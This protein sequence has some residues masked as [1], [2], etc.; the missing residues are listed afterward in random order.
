MNTNSKQVFYTIAFLLSALLTQQRAVCQRTVPGAYPTGTPVNYVRTWDAVAP[1]ADGSAVSGRAVKDMR[2]GTQYID[3]LGRPLQTVVKQ[4]SMA[5]GASAR[6]MVSTVEYDDQGRVRYQYLPYAESSATNGAFKNDPFA[7][8]ASFMNTTYYSSQGETWYYGQTNFEASPLDRPAKSMPP[9]NNWVGSSRGVVSKYWNNTADDHVKKWWVT[10][11]STANQLPTC[12]TGNTTSYEYP[13]GELTKS[14]SVDEHGKQVV[15][16]TNKK[17]QLL[18]KKIQLTATADDGGGADHSGWLCTYYI[19]DMYDNLRCVVQPRGVELLAANSWNIGALSG[20][21]TA[22]QCFQYGYDANNRMTIKKVPGADEVRMVYDK[23]DRLVM[24]QDGNMR[25]GN[26]WLVL[27]YD[28]RSR[29]IESGLWTSSTSF[30]DHLDAAAAT[31]SYPATSGTYTIMTVTHYDDYS[32]L[33]SGL[34]SYD[35]NWNTHFSASSHTTWPYPEMPAKSSNTKGLVTWTK[36]RVIGTSDFLHAVNYY[37]EKGRVIQVQSTNH[38]GGTDITTTQ[39]SWAGQP[40]VVVQKIQ[41]AVAS[42][43]TAIVTRLTYDDLGRPSMVEKKQ[44]Y[45]GVNS[46][47]MSAFKVI[48]EMEYDKQGQMV[49][50]KIGN[51]P[52]SG[53]LETQDYE[54]NIRGWMLGMNR[55]YTRDVNDRYFG[56]DLGYDKTANG[57]INSQTYAAA[58]YNGNISGMV[59]KSKGDGAK[60]KYDFEYDAANRLIKGDFKQYNG[61]SFVNDAMINY[62]MSV[63]EFDGSGN[64]L[65]DGYDA[66][67]NIKKMLQW[68]LKVNS[69]SLIDKLLYE[70]KNS[71]NSNK[72]LSVSEATLGTTDN[73]LGDFTDKNTSNDDYDYDTNGNLTLDKNKAISSITYNHLNLPSVVTITGK[74]TITYTYAANGTKLKKEVQENGAT[75]NGNTTNIT[76]TTTYLAGIVYENKAYSHS[77]VNTALGFSNKLQYWGH[78]EGRVRAKYTAA[79]TPAAEVLES[80]PYDYFIKDHLGN[81]RMTITEEPKEDTYTT[82]SLEGSSSTPQVDDQDAVW[83]KADGTNF[84]VV[85][86]RISSPGAL[87]TS[88]LNPDPEDYSLLVRSSTGKVGAGKL[89]RVMS[90]D[91]IHTSV[92][93]YYSSNTGNGSTDGLNTLVGGLTNVLTNSTGALPAVKDNASGLVS[94]LSSDAGISSFFS[95]Q[96]SGSNNGRPKAFLN[97]LFF[98]EQFRFEPTASYSEQIGSSSVGQVVIAMGSERQAAKN[99]YCYVYISNET[100]DMVY[101]DNLALKHVRSA[102]LDETHYYPFGLTMAAISSKAATSLENRYKF[103]GKEEQRKEFNDGSGL[104]WQDFGARMYDA[105]VGRWNHIDPMSEKMRRHSPYNYAFDNP[106]R[107]IDPDGMAPVEKQRANKLGFRRPSHTVH[108]VT[109]GDKTLAPSDEESDTKSNAGGGNGDADG[110]YYDRNGNFLG[111]DGKDDGKIYLLNSGFRPKH[112][113]K[114]VNWGGQFSEAHATS[115][116][117]HSTEVDGLIIQNRIEEGSDYT[118]SQFKAIGGDKTTVQGYMLE[119]GGPSTATPNQDKRIPEGVYDV[120]SYSSKKYPDNFILSNDQ[121]SKNRKILYHAGNN[122]GNTEGCNMPGSGQVSGTVTGSRAKMQELRGFINNQGPNV[123]TIIN[124]LIE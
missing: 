72:L 71:N 119:P 46:G 56:F 85:G 83:E 55:D 63:G 57:L 58:Q 104:E 102:I 41:N 47:D 79:A 98:D 111:T 81:V 51:G 49:K 84:D 78:E 94:P 59:W 80:L 109:H 48:A 121:V 103:N 76:T 34:G 116:K 96:S 31:D 89:L 3:G 66:N 18:L 88:G 15:L 20:V 114:D 53:P 23:V 9:G 73:K 93:Y 7:A 10:N 117:N 1:E 35:E 75:V 8:Q 64:Y 92:Q 61:S 60:R 124:N 16:F 112:E 97:V 33:P 74:G 26:Q 40:L 54:Y 29:P 99:G 67:G 13:A 69:S 45:P 120:D 42:K 38:T 39:Y 24:S 21:I 11:Y 6:D 27:K 105:Q 90:G 2:M 86:K 19:Y 95:S 50:K 108:E 68:G 100:N 12:S 30:A 4:G 122:G 118:L 101:F 14:I 123:K 5:T 82:L 37:D 28:S 87:Q 52:V 77:T 43:T 62:D 113:N 115:L 32:S 44:Q 25:P 110:D 22:E 70:Y 17:G 106:L 65:H 36:T 91:E 107:F